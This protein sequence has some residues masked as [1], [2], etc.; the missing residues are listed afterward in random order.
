MF[1]KMSTDV[2]KA[3]NGIP[4][5]CQR[6]LP[7]H[8]EEKKDFF[9]LRHLRDLL[10]RLGLSLGTQKLPKR[11]GLKALELSLGLLAT[12]PLLLKGFSP[13]HRARIPLVTPSSPPVRAAKRVEAAVAAPPPSPRGRR[14]PRGGSEAPEAPRTRATRTSWA[15]GPCHAPAARPPCR[16]S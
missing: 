12:N 3:F 9:M 2:S 16:P 15:L 13:L 1:I 14:A 10:R 6:L 5:T 11:L 4:Y 8:R 7:L